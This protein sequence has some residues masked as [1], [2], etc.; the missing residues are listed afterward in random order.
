MSSSGHRRRGNIITQ[1]DAQFYIF[2][3]SANGGWCILLQQND[4]KLLMT[5]AHAHTRTRAH[6]H[7]RTRH[8]NVFVNK[9]KV[10]ELLHE[11]LFYG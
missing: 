7:T 10:K 5:R 3:V 2:T 1:N 6:A 8:S 9:I 11:S 4:G